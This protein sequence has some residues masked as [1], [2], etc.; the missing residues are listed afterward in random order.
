MMSKE[1]FERRFAE[2]YKSA[3]LKDRGTKKW[4]AMMLPE[5]T[6]DLR[7]DEAN[8]GKVDRPQ[9]DQY[10]LDYIQDEVQRAITIKSQVTI[11]LWA[12]GEFKKLRGTIEDVNLVK[13]YIE[14]EDSFNTLRY[15]FDDVVGIQ[16]E[17]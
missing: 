7:K 14:V 15:S 5:H 2:N 1:E 9:L 3:K 12:D 11:K 10:D 16:L 8:Y 13:R 4:T 6:I 17:G